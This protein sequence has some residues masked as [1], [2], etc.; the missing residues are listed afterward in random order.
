[1]K[2]VLHL[3]RKFTSKTE[4]FIINQVNT[5]KNY[6]VVVATIYNTKLLLCDKIIITPKNLSFLSKSAKFLSSKTAND[7]Y[8]QLK[9]IKIDLI[10]THYLVD[11]IFFSKLTKLFS[12]PKIC[13]AYGYD[14][15]SFPNHFFGFP[16]LLMK[17][18]F[19]EYDYFLAMSEDMKNDL[20][21]LKCID[22]KIKVHYYGTDIKRFLINNRNYEINGKVKILSVGTVEEKKAQHLVIEALSKVNKQIN[23]FEYHIV[24]SG[25]Y[26]EKCKNKVEKFGLKDKVIFHGYIPHYNDRLVKFYQEADIFI[27]PSITLKNYDKEGIPGTIVEAMASGL[28]IIS[29]Y[30]AG[31]PSII[32]NEKEGLLVE[33]KNVIGL[34]NSIYRLIKD[35]NLRI[36]IGKN[37]QKKAIDELDLYKGTERL[38]K[39]YEE[40]LNEKNNFKQKLK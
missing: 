1:M 6:N 29:T 4:T 35:K 30:H 39:I 14:V 33:E 37:A 15:T 28:P 20:L 24:G 31:I 23:D 22:N 11:A 27:L 5:I 9:N 25:E 13:S 21:K 2:T 3:E 7:L 36:K 16:K 12:V 26:L 32:E 38:E 18:I 40:T 8:K 34:T 10:H 19:K 17:N